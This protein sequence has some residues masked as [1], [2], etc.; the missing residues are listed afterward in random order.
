MQDLKGKLAEIF[1][2]CGFDLEVLYLILCFTGPDK[3]RPK[4]ILWTNSI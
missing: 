4:S 3:P 2:A 1:I